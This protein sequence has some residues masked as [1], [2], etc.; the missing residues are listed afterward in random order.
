MTSEEVV[1]VLGFLTG[2]LLVGIVGH[3]FDLVT[4]FIKRG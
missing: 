2:G 4:S 3:W 1:A